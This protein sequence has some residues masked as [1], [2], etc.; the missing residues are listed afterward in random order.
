MAVADKIRAIPGYEDM[1]IAEISKAIG[2]SYGVVY[3]TV[4]KKGIK[5]RK[6]MVQKIFGVPKE[7]RHALYR[8]MNRE[9]I[10]SYNTEYQRE[11][12]LKIKKVIDEKKLQ[13]VQEDEVRLKN[14]NKISIAFG[15]SV[16]FWRKINQ[17]DQKELS[18]RLSTSRPYVAKI[19]K[20]HV[21]VSFD[22]IL[23]IAEALSVNYLT[24]LHCPDE[25][26]I[27]IIKDIYNDFDLGV[28]KQELEML[29]N[30]SFFKG[31]AIT[32]DNYKSLLE[33]FRESGGVIIDPQ[34]EDIQKA[35]PDLLKDNFAKPYYSCR[36]EKLLKI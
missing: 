30:K 27:D 26:E 12:R 8:D 19:E 18:V 36:A 2:R 23:T 20:A 9:K 5:F 21:G 34:H 24:L 6:K 22:K 3:Y 35:A 10:R 29:W 11:R 1:T 13:N 31:E 32:F 33:M 28:T 15:N 4:N 14:T 16:K 25:N 17:F 7:K